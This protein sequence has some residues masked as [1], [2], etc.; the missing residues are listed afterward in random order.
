MPKYDVHLYAVVRLKI[1][2]IG[3]ETQQEAMKKADELIAPHLYDLLYAEK[4][5]PIVEC[6]EYAEEIDGYLVDEI[7]DEEYLKSTF[8][9]KRKEPV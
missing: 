8:Y 9:N 6:T 2:D 3:A 1:P 4:P 5:I 7:G